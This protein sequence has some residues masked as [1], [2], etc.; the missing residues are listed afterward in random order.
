MLFKRGK[1]IMKTNKL[2]DAIT[3]TQYT[4]EEWKAYKKVE[5]NCH[6]CDIMD[7][8]DSRLEEKTITKKQYE[9][10]CNNYNTILNYYEDGLGNDDTWHIALDCA[11]DDTLNVE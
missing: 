3:E 2:K 5:E 1:L 10:L 11:V 4:N 8:L 9:F 6:L 7:E